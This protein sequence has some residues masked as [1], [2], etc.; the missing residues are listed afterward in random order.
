MADSCSGWRGRAELQ[1]IRARSAQP[2]RT[3]ARATRSTW[4][5]ERC[6]D[7]AA[8]RRR[9]LAACAGCGGCLAR[10]RGRLPRRRSPEA[11]RRPLRPAAATT[12]DRDRT[13]VEETT[14]ANA[15]DVR[16]RSSELTQVRQISRRLD[17]AERATNAAAQRFLG[18]GGAGSRCSARAFGSPPAPS[19]PSPRTLGDAGFRQS[20]FRE[21]QP[22]QLD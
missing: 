19:S 4:G 15:L 10:R 18:S 16:K 6:G 14:E 1:R 7:R 12:R 13:Q 20:P 11:H 22:F 8:G 2:S 9:G 21:L 5:A 3:G 17:V